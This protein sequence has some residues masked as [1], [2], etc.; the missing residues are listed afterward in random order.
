MYFIVRDEVCVLRLFAFA[1]FLKQHVIYPLTAANKKG[2]PKFYWKQFRRV[3][4]PLLP[5]DMLRLWSVAL[6]APTMS[7]TII[8]PRERVCLAVNDQRRPLEETAPRV[9]GGGQRKGNAEKRDHTFRA[10]SVHTP[11]PCAP[12]SQSRAKG[13]LESPQGQIHTYISTCS[14]RATFVRQAVLYIWKFVSVC[15]EIRVQLFGEYIWSLDECWDRYWTAG[16][17]TCW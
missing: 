3:I 4:T 16:Y 15:L 5:R 12:R 13:S 2:P 8:D 9:G 17:V 7:G 10:R 11:R 14:C 6:G 1:S